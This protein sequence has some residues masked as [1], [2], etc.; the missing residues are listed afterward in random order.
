MNIFLIDDMSTIFFGFDGDFRV[1]R[2]NGN[3]D[4]MAT[5]NKLILSYKKKGEAM[6][7]AAYFNEYYIEFEGEGKDYVVI[8]NDGEIALVECKN[9]KLVFPAIKEYDIYK[10]MPTYCDLE[11][12]LKKIHDHENVLGL[13]DGV[14]ELKMVT[15]KFI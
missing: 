12:M 10:V 7:K 8:S 4:I 2:K 5:T 11:P 6:K 14:I 9:G 3:S 13:L 1:L 15:P